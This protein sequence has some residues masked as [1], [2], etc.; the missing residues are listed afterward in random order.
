[1]DDAPNVGRRDQ[2]AAREVRSLAG[3]PAFARRARQ[4]E[5]AWETLLVR[6]RKQREE[7]LSLVRLNMGRLFALAGVEEEPED[8]E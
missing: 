7:W 2:Q 8:G 6:C 3:G 5:E 4:V 1:M